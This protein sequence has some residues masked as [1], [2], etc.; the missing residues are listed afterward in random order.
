MSRNHVILEVTDE[1]QPRLTR[2]GR[3]IV[4]FDPRG[5]LSRIVAARAATPVRQS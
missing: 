2:Y 4:T 1:G 5:S 3:V